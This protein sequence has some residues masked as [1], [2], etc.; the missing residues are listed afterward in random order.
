MDAPACSQIFFRNYCGVSPAE[1]DGP[2][3]SELLLDPEVVVLSLLLPTPLLGVPEL[4]VPLLLPALPPELSG[5]L[6]P[7]PTLF[8]SPLEPYTLGPDAPCELLFD[9]CELSEFDL[10][11]F[12]PVVP[13]LDGCSTEVELLE[14]ASLD[15]SGEAVWLSVEPLC[16]L[17]IALELLCELDE[18]E[19]VEPLL[20]PLRV[21]LE[22]EEL[23]PLGAPTLVSVLVGL[24]PAFP[25]PGV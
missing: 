18:L 3:A 4:P 7:C 9:G 25:V 20:D 21:P 15:V 13:R 12:E 1:V 2:D 23:D 10:L 19:S 8:V 22:L 24:E 6:L 14:L 16:P 17:S 11:W 5:W